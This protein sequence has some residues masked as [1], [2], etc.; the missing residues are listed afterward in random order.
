MLNY[1]S[2]A[3]LCLCNVEQSI[4][5]WY[6]NVPYI[7]P[8]YA[9]KSFPNKSLM[10]L[11]HNYNFG[12]DCASRRE[13]EMAKT[14]T[15]DI[16]Y[17]NP[18]KSVDDIIFAKNN[19]VTEYVVDSVEEVRKIENIDHGANYIVRVLANE[20]SSVI[21]FNKKF[22]AALCDAEKIMNYI[23]KQ[24]L[25]FMGY[26]YH[27]GSK[28]KSMDAHRYTISN[29]LYKYKP[30]SDFY[31]LPTKLIDIGGGFEKTAQLHELHGELYNN[32]LLEEMERSGIGLVA[33]PGR[34][35]SSKALN[36]FTKVIAVRKKEEQG[37]DVYYITIND[38]VYHS[39]QG[40]IFDYQT[41]EPIPLYSDCTSIIDGGGIMCGGDA[42]SKCVI[43][44]QT[45]D[46]LDVIC[47]CVYLPVPKLGD[48]ILFRDVGA[49]SLASA[50]GTFNGFEAAIIE[51]SNEVLKH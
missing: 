5:N 7:R 28:C 24:N 39:F 6:R 13:I 49:Y 12:F 50:T 22:G 21:K 48:V 38:S 40:R 20:D 41:F 35:I 30:M 26:S 9:V 23:A 16:I 51:E 4:K 42:Y 1:R 3:K 25:N 32:G 46:S 8:Y 27:V 47:D 43:F 18:T 10:E 14:F 17:G 37:R 2:V 29:I 33:E 44:G 34:I 15:H 31:G 36:I 45:C 19:N 11:L